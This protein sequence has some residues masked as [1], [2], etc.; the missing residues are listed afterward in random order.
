MR[1]TSVQVA[2]WRLRPRPP[3]KL[4]FWTILSQPFLK[5]IFN[6][7]QSLWVVAISIIKTTSLSA[8]V[9]QLYYVTGHLEPFSL[10][11]LISAWISNH[12]PSKVWGEI[13]YQLPN[14]NDCN[15]AIWEC[16]SNSIVHFI[17]DMITHSCWIKDNKGSLVR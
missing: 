13:T 5:C 8:S 2:L 9:Q 6:S 17:M 14:F 10:T 12:I 4:S 3:V 1:I 16:I 11:I 15:I 7:L